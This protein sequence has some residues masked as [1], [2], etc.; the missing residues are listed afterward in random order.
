MEPRNRFQGIHSASLC[1]LA[2]RYN[3]SIPTRFLAPVDCLKIPALYSILYCMSVLIRCIRIIRRININNRSIVIRHLHM[4]LFQKGTIGQIFDNYRQGFIL[5]SALIIV[6]YTDVVST[7]FHTYRT[8]R[9]LY[10][11]LVTVY[12]HI[13]FNIPLVSAYSILK[14]LYIRLIP[15]QND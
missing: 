9:R 11:N 2:G 3:N 12:Y 5:Y 4:A 1:S 14:W 6:V 15:K 13:D 8:L 7:S 10:I